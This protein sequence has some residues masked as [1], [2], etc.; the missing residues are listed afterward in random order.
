MTAKWAMVILVGLIS[1]WK[2]TAAVLLA[3]GLSYFAWKKSGAAS[4]GLRA[5]QTSVALLCAWCLALLVIA[6]AI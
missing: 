6:G 4:P 5:F 1:L 3:G 2:Y